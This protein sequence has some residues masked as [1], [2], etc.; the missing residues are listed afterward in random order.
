MSDSKI[1]SEKRLFDTI[2]NGSPEERSERMRASVES[3]Q[4]KRTPNGNISGVRQKGQG[5]LTA[6]QRLFAGLIVEGHSQSEAYRRAY[7]VRTDNPA[8]ISNSAYKLAQHPKVARLLEQGISKR[9]DS[10][11]NDEIATRRLVMSALLDHAQNMKAESSKLKALELIGK[12]VG[13]FTD[14]VEQK[15]S[16]IDTTKLKDELSH[17]LKLLDQIPDDKS[18]DKNRHH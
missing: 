7:D 6:K 16:E 12:A 5:K 17:H 14:K 18:N 10:V 9:T 1:A 13:M 4:E 2:K 8:V 11:I 15:V 3:I